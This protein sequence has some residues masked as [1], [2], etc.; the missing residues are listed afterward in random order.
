MS[1]LKDLNDDLQEVVDFHGY[2]VTDCGQPEPKWLL[3]NL[4]R[5]ALAQYICQT[6]TPKWNDSQVK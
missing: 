3:V 2:L 1:G 6:F 4:L 5:V